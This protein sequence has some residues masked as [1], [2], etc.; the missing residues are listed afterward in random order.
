MAGET[1]PGTGRDGQQATRDERVERLAHEL[2]REVGSATAE[3]REEL[4]EYAT[5]LL[6]SETEASGAEAPADAERR[7][8][9]GPFAFAL[10]FLLAGALFA[11]LAPPLGVVLLIA[12]AVGFGW[13]VVRLVVG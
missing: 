8:P 9:L 3:D 4:R 11:V 10:L 13:G 7:R 5:E 2:A 1:P 12:A 6:R